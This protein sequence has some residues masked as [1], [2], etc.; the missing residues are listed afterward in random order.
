MVR[1]RVR[2]QGST[3]CHTML[4]ANVSSAECGFYAVLPLACGRALSKGVAQRDCPTERVQGL[5]VRGGRATKTG[6]AGGSSWGQ[7]RMLAALRGAGCAS[8]RR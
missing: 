6:A 5:I 8:E 1:R 2:M 7:Q 4:G 3:W